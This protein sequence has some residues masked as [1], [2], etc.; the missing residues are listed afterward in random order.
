MNPI[1]Y[2]KKITRT[3]FL[4]PPTTCTETTTVILT[5]EEAEE[6]LLNVLKKLK[7]GVV[8]ILRYYFDKG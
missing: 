2:E 4:Q 8:N 1:T 6:N 3:M 7:F 5:A